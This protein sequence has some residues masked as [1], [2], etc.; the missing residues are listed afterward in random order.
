M[1]EPPPKFIGFFRLID[2]CKSEGCPVCRCL[3]ADTRHCLDTLLYERVNDPETRARLHAS[4]GFCNWHGWM[5]RETPDSAFGSAI[6]G[7]DLLRVLMRRFER[8]ALT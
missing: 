4:W 6:L 3:E 8:S 1:A 7:E 2:A 5:L